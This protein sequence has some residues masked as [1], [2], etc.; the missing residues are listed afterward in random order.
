MFM[1]VPFHSNYSA[2]DRDGKQRPE[3]AGPACGRLATE[4]PFVPQREQSATLESTP[5]MNVSGIE[6]TVKSMP[7]ST[8]RLFLL[9]DQIA[10]PN[11]GAG[12]VRIMG[13]RIVRVR[14]VRVRIVRVRIMRVRIVGVR[15]PSRPSGGRLREWEMLWQNPM[16]PWRN[17]AVLIPTK[18]W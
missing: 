2:S 1:L 15:S 13:V 7:T 9:H 18:S 6:Q 16:R 4:G 5:K 11:Q 14:I 10:R 17:D 3:S 8:A 12:R